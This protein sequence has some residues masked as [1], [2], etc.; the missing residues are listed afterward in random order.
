LFGF[1]EMSMESIFNVV[2]IEKFNDSNPS[3]TQLS[4]HIIP[5]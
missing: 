5:N 2:F 3:S 1:I 4:I